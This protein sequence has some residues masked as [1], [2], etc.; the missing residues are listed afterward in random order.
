M[1]DG[2]MP[3]SGAEPPMTR[4]YM[5][6]HEKNPLQPT[7][8]NLAHG[9][10]L[11]LN[12]CAPCHGENGRGIGPVAHLLNTKPKDLVGGLSKNL[13]DGYIYG[14]IR[15]GGIAMPSLDDAMSAHERWDVVMFVRAL[16]Q[17]ASSSAAAQH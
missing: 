7:P 5:T 10:E 14:T 13:P 4:E 8:E 12:N 1:P 16:Q 2:T 6:I 15:D 3:T 9:K 17:A 11:F